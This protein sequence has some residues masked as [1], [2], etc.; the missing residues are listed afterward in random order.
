MI[1]INPKFAR[2]VT[3]IAFNLTLT[4]NMVVTLFDIATGESV[5]R[6]TF[7]LLGMP[8]NFVS[9]LNGL[10]D[11]GLVYAPDPEWP[12]RCLMTKEGEHVFALLQAAGI[13]QQIE[14]KHK[15]A[16]A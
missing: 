8:S 12:G 16:A 2:S 6:D 13:V 5:R 3:S 4:K 11:R 10:L 1:D 7:R 14:D 9:G 15:E